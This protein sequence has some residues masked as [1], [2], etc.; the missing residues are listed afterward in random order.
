[1]A[2]LR[3]GLGIAPHLRL[4]GDIAGALWC[5][6]VAGFVL[7]FAFWKV[8]VDHNIITPQRYSVFLHCDLGFYTELYK[9]CL[10]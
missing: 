4:S 9:T 8:A 6:L 2:V 3:W 5:K 10:P 1:M 7:F